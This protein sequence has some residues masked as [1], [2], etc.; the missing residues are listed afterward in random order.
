[1]G[2]PVQKSL[3]DAGW[4]AVIK[5]EYSREYSLRLGLKARLGLIVAVWLSGLSS[6]GSAWRLGSA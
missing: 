3:L 5:L 6:S 1:M 4:F 2:E